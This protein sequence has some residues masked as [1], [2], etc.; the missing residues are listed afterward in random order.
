MPGELVFPAQPAIVGGGRVLPSPAAFY[1][2]GEDRL[3]IVSVNSLAGV[4]LKMQWRVA[5]SKGA[6]VPNS[7]D[8]T[9]NADR[10]VKTTDYELGTGSL[11][12]ITVFASAGAPLIGQTYVMVQLV[13]GFGAAAIVLGTLLGGYVTAT[14]ALGFPGSPILSPL[15]GPG[16]FRV[17]TGTNPA[18]GFSVLET[19]PAG[20]R[21]DLVTFVNTLVAS[22]AVS[23]RFVT[24][25]I[26][27]SGAATVRMWA[28]AAQVASETRL[29]MASQAAKQSSLLIGGTTYVWLGL[30]SPCIMRAGDFIQDFTVGITG[31]DDWAAPIYTV[32]EWLEP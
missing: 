10:T 16:Y 17:I 30:P 1:A 3:R 11:L 20:A 27:A 9:P 18:A 28:D 4:R 7:V 29:Y 26:V 6:T 32:R 31:T 12:N 14:A 24:L 25:L 22:A 19:V 15:D 8:H 21:W 23:N 2:T 13:R 5:D